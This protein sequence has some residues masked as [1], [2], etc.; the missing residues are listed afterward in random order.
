MFRRSRAFALVITF[1]LV[2][3]SDGDAR[4]RP[5]RPVEVDRAKVRAYNIGLTSLFTLVNATV[6]G[7]VRSVRDAVRHLLIGSGAGYSFYQAKRMAGGGRT[8]EG[9]LLANATSSIV[10]NTS[11][12]EHPVGR[13]GYTVGPM[14]LRFATPFARKALAN[15][16]LDW[17]L[18]ETAYL[19]TA[20]REGDHVRWRDGLI[21]VDDETGW[22]DPDRENVVFT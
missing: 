15:I 11:S 6:Q 7:E 12:G 22:P 13:I 3:A 1:A 9:W 18:A 20:L 14:R 16:E 8:T 2:V 21:A 10:E 5:I 19:I 17:S 4:D